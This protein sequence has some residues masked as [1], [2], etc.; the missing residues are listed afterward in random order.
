MKNQE[1]RAQISIFEDNAIKW[2]FWNLTVPHEGA[3][4]GDLRPPH[5]GIYYKTLRH[6]MLWSQL[7]FMA[8]ILIVR[9]PSRIIRKNT[10][11]RIGGTHRRLPLLFFSV[12]R[13]GSPRG[14]SSRSRKNAAAQYVLIVL[15]WW[16]GCGSSGLSTWFLLEVGMLAPSAWHMPES[17]TP[18]RTAGAEH[19]PHCLC[20]Q[21]RI[22]E[23]L[24]SLRKG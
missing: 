24:V 11:G 16:Y 1:G 20:K 15:P 9:I 17:H 8:C 4:L 18:R 12:S 5:S 7:R 6:R 22:S 2:Y 14:H 3:V 21:L 19:K 13:E 23:R 10:T